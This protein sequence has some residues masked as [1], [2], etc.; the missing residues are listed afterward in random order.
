MDFL[1]SPVVC[2]QELE[3]KMVTSCPLV[4]LRD[5]AETDIWLR[6]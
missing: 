1:L 5:N 4:T 2:T 6:Q 3:S